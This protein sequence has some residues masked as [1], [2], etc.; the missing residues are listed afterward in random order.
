MEN[1]V[2]RWNDI[3][4]KIWIQNTWN[5]IKLGAKSTW[6]WVLEHPMETI[7]IAGG[8]AGVTKKACG[9]YKTHAEDVRRRRDFYDPRT[10][11]HS[12]VR[13]DLKGWEEELID[14]RYN[15]GE[16]YVSILRD[17]NLMK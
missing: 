15:N 13:R 5:K 1:K 16:S 6:D 3:K 2:P 10:G 17:M 14:E 9:A 4:R 11:R 12:Y 8:V 7:A